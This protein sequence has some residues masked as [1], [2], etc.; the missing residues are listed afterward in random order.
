MFVWL[1][2]LLNT[3]RMDADLGKGER[4]LTMMNVG[5][6]F[7]LALEFICRESEVTLFAM[8]FLTA[9]KFLSFLREG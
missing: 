5:T 1:L 2:Q 7:L 6:A 8:V 4:K 3:K 9:A